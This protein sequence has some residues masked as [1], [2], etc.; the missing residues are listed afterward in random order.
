MTD[1]KINDRLFVADVACLDDTEL[2]TKCYA[3]AGEGRREKTDRL[4][5]R[6]DKNLSLGVGLLLR[7][8]MLECGIPAD[9]QPVAGPIGKL[10]FPDYPDFNFNLS[11]SGTKAV[12]AVSSVPV[13]CDI[14]IIAYDKTERLR[15]ISHRFFLPSEEKMIVSQG[16][17]K[18]EAETFFRFW[19]LKESFMKVTGEG[20]K[21]APDTFELDLTGPQVQIKQD[22][23]KENDYH[24][25]EFTDVDGYCLSV[26]TKGK[27]F[28][29]SVNIIS[30]LPHGV[31]GTL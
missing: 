13:G 21:L 19:T 20:M 16:S 27:P 2:F 22:Y 17:E 4:K 29:A 28:E 3:L 9:S 26:C 1:K 12:C 25:V 23:D 15:K 6:K 8:A 11:H 7:K 5:F 24:F 14:E 31:S 18:A 10:Y 30:C